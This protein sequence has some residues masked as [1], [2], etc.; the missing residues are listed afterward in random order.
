MVHCTKP[1]CTKNSHSED[2]DE[3]ELLH[4]LRYIFDLFDFKF[5]FKLN[6]RVQSYAPKTDLQVIKPWGPLT[7]V[8]M[9]YEALSFFLQKKTFEKTIKLI[10]F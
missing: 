9:G 10:C 4:A 2:N 1:V 8:R 3:P 6:D 5:L 7:S